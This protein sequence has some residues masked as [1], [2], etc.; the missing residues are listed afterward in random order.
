MSVFCLAAIKRILQKVFSLV[1][2]S[3]HC[4]TNTLYLPV[5]SVDMISA[6]S[7][8]PLTQRYVTSGLSVK[9]SI[10]SPEAI[11]FSYRW[12][13]LQGNPL[14][15]TARRNIRSFPATRPHRTESHRKQITKKKASSQME[16]IIRNTLFNLSI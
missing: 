6:A 7:F 3:L 16:S 5:F 11:W 2:K 10:F 9:S 15:E 4:M 14:Q 1:F 12:H 8:I 13:F